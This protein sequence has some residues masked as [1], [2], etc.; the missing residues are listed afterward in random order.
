[1][2]HEPPTPQDDETAAPRRLTLPRMAGWGAAALL[3][4]L[5]VW[6]IA[7]QQLPVTVYKLSLISLAAVTGYWIDRSMFPYARPDRLFP[8]PHHTGHR[9]S[10]TLLWL[11]V[12]VAMLR[13]AI[14]VAAAML[15][16][17]L[18]A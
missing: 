6:W 14:V 5:G 13:R 17:S 3:L 15:A 12:C 4:S 16:I 2:P 1:M 10:L 8:A 7:P 18:G 11:V 9:A